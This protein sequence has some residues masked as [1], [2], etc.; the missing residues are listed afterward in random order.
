MKKFLIIFI[1]FI[2]VTGCGSNNK[3][4]SKNRVEKRTFNDLPSSLKYGDSMQYEDILSDVVADIKKVDAE[5]ELSNY[6]FSIEEPS[7]AYLDY[8]IDGT[9]K[10]DKRYQFLFDNLY[11]WSLGTVNSKLKTDL[12][13][14]DKKIIEEQ[15]NKFEKDKANI[16]CKHAKFMCDG[17]IILN[18]ENK[19]VGGTIENMKN[20]NEEYVYSF[21][22]HQIYYHINAVLEPEIYGAS[23]LFA[24]MN[25]KN[26]KVT[27]NLDD[28]KKTWEKSHK[29]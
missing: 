2:C 17:N 12:T 25:L 27:N 26:Y 7:I 19:I 5:F 29:K 22:N 10:T 20:I 28:W 11:Y 1:L 16:I 8:F 3:T 4:I 18:D 13:D 6:K 24:K 21:K 9:L 14:E 15:I 23:A